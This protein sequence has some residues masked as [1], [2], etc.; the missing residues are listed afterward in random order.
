MDAARI[1]NAKLTSSL[2]GAKA[3]IDQ[4]G[5]QNMT[6][7]HMAARSRHENVAKILIDAGCHTNIKAMVAHVKKM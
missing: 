4:T 1:G 7:L 5:P 3:H 6:A 2:I